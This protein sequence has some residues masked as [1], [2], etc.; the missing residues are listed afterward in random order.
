LE[1]YLDPGTPQ[2]CSG[3]HGSNP[4][5]RK[6]AAEPRIAWP[7]FGDELPPAKPPRLYFAR[8]HQP[9]LDAVTT[10]LR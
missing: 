9:Q 2:G 4:A 6:F 8:E 1:K 10:M 3:S 5:F 7:A